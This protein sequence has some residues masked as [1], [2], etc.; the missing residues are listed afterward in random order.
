MK[1]ILQ[2]ILTVCQ[3]DTNLKLKL[4]DASKKET[5]V[6]KGTAH[7]EQFGEYDIDVE[8]TVENV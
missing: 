2:L 5:V 1:S 4:T 3:K 6:K 8:V 7:I